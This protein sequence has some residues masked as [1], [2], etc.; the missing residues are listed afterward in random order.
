MRHPRTASQAA[1]ANLGLEGTATLGGVDHSRDVDVVDPLRDGGD[2]EGQRV[3]KE[4]GVDSGAEY[5]LAGALRG[6]VHHRS[7]AAV[8]T[9]RERQLLR[10]G[11]DVE[12]GI[13]YFQYLVS[14]LIEIGVGGVHDNTGVGADLD[15]LG[16]DL[17][18]QGPVETNYLTHVL[19]DLGR[20]DVD[21]SHQLETFALV[22]QSCAGAADGAEPVLNDPRFLIHVVSPPFWVNP[23]GYSA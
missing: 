8:V 12:P 4:S 3:Q 19:A 2:E 17:D 11:N 14:E 13:E 18:A 5:C 16:L 7:L 15:Q 1:G 21:R 22:D 10:G 9:P 6:L 20:I 23:R